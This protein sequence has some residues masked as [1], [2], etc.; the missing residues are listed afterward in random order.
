MTPYS[1]SWAAAQQ[2]SFLQD[3]DERRE[4]LRI[5]QGAFPCSEHLANK[6]HQPLD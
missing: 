3:R 6:R 4:R 5:L 2:R 1:A